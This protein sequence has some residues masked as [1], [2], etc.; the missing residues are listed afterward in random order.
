MDC[1]FF[2]LPG[3][4]DD[5][6]LD[7][8]QHPTATYI[9]KP[10]ASSRGRGVRLVQD[11]RSLD[12]ASLKDVILQR[13]IS[14]PLLIGGRKFDLRVY[15]AVTCLDPL[16]VYVY[17]EGEVYRICELLVS[18]DVQR[19][20]LIMLVAMSILKATEAAAWICMM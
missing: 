7:L 18:Y 15:V 19:A 10:A 20:E 12:L 16:R 2:I 9:R 11:P 4:A 1:R 8:A 14:E 6:K 5:F 3:D 13:Y 17:R